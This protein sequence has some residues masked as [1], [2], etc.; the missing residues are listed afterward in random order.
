MFCWSEHVP[1]GVAGPSPR[2]S[3]AYLASPSLRFL[4]LP[5]G[6]PAAPKELLLGLLSQLQ[7][8][9]EAPEAA[10]PAAA[11]ATAGSSALRAAAALALAHAALPLAAPAAS[12]DQFVLP[13]L[14]G[15]D[16]IGKAAA[17]LLQDKDPKVVQ[18]AA[19]ALGY[20]C[21]AHSGLG[22]PA[23]TAA[24]AT[25]GTSSGA[26]PAE[27]ASAA[28]GNS[29]SNG[30]D[31]GLLDLSVSALLGLQTSKN[32]EVLFAVGEA[33]SFCFGGE[34]MYGMR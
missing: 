31:G 19:A 26:A 14:P 18:R 27:G 30:G 16:G 20:L 1:G 34:P 17:G 11:S 29:S 9:L 24:T 6:T 5:T 28:G 15:V 25:A 10:A 33:L 8:L 2:Q 12:P 7:Q 32:E 4:R 21:W 23:T 3:T 13:G 22:G